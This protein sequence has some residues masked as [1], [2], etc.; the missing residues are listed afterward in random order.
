MEEGWDTTALRQALLQAGDARDA[1]EL[2]HKF[3]TQQFR[4]RASRAVAAGRSSANAATWWRRDPRRGSATPRWPYSATRGR[5]FPPANASA[6]PTSAASSN[7]RVCSTGSA[8]C[9]NAT[10]C[11]VSLRLRRGRSAARSLRLAGLSI[12]LSGLPEAEK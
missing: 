8:R 5:L 6:W 1:N 9:S 3:Y 12:E 11:T 7:P 10:A 4:G 2:M